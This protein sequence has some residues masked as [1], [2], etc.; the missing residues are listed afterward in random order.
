MD[1]M[2]DARQIKEDIIKVLKAYGCKDT[3]KV[4]VEIDKQDVTLRGIVNS[5]EL[6]TAIGHVAWSAR[7]VEK[8]NDQISIPGN[9]S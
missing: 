9:K 6:R 1:I 5:W 3:S 4:I 7:G 2:P 8:V